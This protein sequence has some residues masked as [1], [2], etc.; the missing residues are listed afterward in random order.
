[1]YLVYYKMENK[2]IL[3]KSFNKALNGGLSGSV[4]M[5]FQVCSM[6]WLRTTLNY[7]YKHGGTF[8]NNI[9]YLYSQGGVPRFYRGLVPALFQAP[10]SRFGD[11]AANIGMMNYL[12]NNSSTSNLPISVKTFCGSTF[13]GLWRINLMP[14]DTCK[15]INQV[16][17]KK[18]YSILKQKISTHG[19]RVLYHGSLGACGATIIGH[20][21]WFF[22]FNTLSE[23][24]PKSD[25]NNI[26]Y[27]MGRYAG[28]GFCSSL[29]SDTVSNF[30][31]VIKVS[32][33]TN[34]KNTSY[35]NI[36]TNIINE[37]GIK[38]LFGR[39]LKTKIII[40]GLQGI[41]FTVVWKSCEEVLNQRSNF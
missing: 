8:I 15:T 27:K 14:I 17:G 9:K 32:K 13:A 30:S 5:G 10:L 37:K 34:I 25:N 22:T 20:F 1:M 31:R 2:S 35:K 39:G 40:N 18:G 36:I 4:A 3:Q 19:I 33:Q 41:V 21:P 26:L 16:H 7:Q 11:T 24:I 23:K 28:I 38:E 6:M 12:N 29:V